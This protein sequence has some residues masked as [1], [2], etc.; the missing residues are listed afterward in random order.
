MGR[1]NTRT[2]AHVCFLLIPALLV[3][4][5]GRAVPG[6]YVVLT[7]VAHVAM[8]TAAGVALGFWYRVMV[9]R[10]VPGVQ[11]AIFTM[12]EKVEHEANK[13][14]YAYRFLRARNN[15]LETV[16]K[17]HSQGDTLNRW[18]KRSLQA[19]VVTV[20]T[21]AF[22]LTLEPMRLLLEAVK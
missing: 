20:A 1:A 12:D 19:T 3:L 7:A 4:V 8:F 14:D 10:P 9:T 21:A 17:A 6:G 5:A 11:L 16:E 15:L 18:R 13:H 22:P 2:Q